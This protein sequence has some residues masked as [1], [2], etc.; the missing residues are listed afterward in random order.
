LGGIGPESTGRFYLSLISKFQE[1][2]LIKSNKDFPQIIINSIPASE[3]IYN[4]IFDK[5][6]ELYIRGLRELENFGVD[7]IAMICN[8]IYLYYEK[9]QS[10]IKV[11]IIDL[12]KEV[13]N[14]LINKRIKSVGVLASPN[15]IKNGLYRFENIECIIPSDKEIKML[16]EAV[17]NFNKGFDKIEQSKIVKNIAKGCIKRGAKIIILGCTE[18]ALMLKNENIPKIDTMD[19]L[20]ESIIKHIIK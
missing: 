17:F 8:T 20:V 16:S 14:Y 7:F 18:V 10:E 19:M 3:L 6:L 9:L 12:R 11:P 2:K 15:V 4:D 1:K 13:K 5:D